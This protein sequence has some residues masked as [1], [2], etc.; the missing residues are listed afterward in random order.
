MLSD[1]EKIKIKKIADSINTESYFTGF[2]LGLISDWKKESPYPD[3]PLI[4]YFIVCLS[5]N[6]MNNYQKEI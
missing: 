4:D 5:K 3:D 2:I 6:F 1:E